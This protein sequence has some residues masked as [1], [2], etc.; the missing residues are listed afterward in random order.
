MSEETILKYQNLLDLKI[1]YASVLTDNLVYELGNRLNWNEA[2]KIK[3][4]VR[5]LDKHKNNLNWKIHLLHNKLSEDI[6]MMFS[7]YLDWSTVSLTQDLSVNFILLNESKM[8]WNK[9][10]RRV[11]YYYIFDMVVDERHIDSIDWD[12]YAGKPNLPDDFILKKL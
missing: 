2:S 6:I 10:Y 12:L 5:T 8:D 3:L 9:I 11:D 7:N 1:L 4:E